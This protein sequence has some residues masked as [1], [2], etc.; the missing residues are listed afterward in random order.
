MISLVK[1]LINQ[2]KFQ[3]LILLD[4]AQPNASFLITAFFKI[5]MKIKFISFI[6][7]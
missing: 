3:I 6:P 7:T 4:V 1:I 2:H 5:Q